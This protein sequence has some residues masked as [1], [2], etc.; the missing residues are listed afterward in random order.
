[1]KKVLLILLVAASA[2]SNAQVYKIG[3]NN[4]KTLN[5]CKG[6]FVSS[7][8]TTTQNGINGVAG[9]GY[10]EN[11]SVTFCSGD[12]ARKM[13]ANFYYLNIRTGFD[14]LYIYEVMEDLI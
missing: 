7:M 6:Q 3:E 14:Y 4:G 9:Y 2:I 13:R 8:F 5:V 11:Y 10:S 1:M 12:P